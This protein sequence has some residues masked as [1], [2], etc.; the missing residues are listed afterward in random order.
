MVERVVETKLPTEYGEFKM[1]AY[2]STIDDSEH[3]ALVLG[4]IDETV[5]VLVRVQSEC[6]TGDIFKSLRCDCNA[7]L[8]TSLKA[9]AE[10]G[11]GVLVYME[12]RRSRY[13]AYQ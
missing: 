3:L 6:L 13:W 12:T 1:M 5:P 11:S 7:Q 9:I 10:A 2:K 8:D 4:E